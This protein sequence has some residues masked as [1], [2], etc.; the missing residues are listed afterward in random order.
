MRRISQILWP[1]LRLLLL[2]VSW[3]AW[4]VGAVFFLCMLGGILGIAC[5]VYVGEMGVRQALAGI[6]VIVLCAS[7]A[8]LCFAFRHFIRSSAV[9]V[10][11]GACLAVPGTARAQLGVIDLA[12]IAQLKT[13]LTQAR[14][15]VAEAMQIFSAL[16]HPQNVLGLAPELSAP[17]LQNLLPN[18]GQLNG[19]LSG[20][21]ASNPL[22]ALIA[23]IRQ[24]NQF[25]K[26]Q[27][28]DF[29]ANWINQSA[30][31]NAGV[32]AL[33]QNMVAALQQRMAGL[34]DLEQSCLG[35]ASDVTQLQACSARLQGE[36]NYAQT[37]LGEAQLLKTLADEQDR[38]QQQQ[39]MQKARQD[40][41][42]LYQNTQPLAEVPPCAICG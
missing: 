24:Q 38:A 30:A 27:G 34:N 28:S 22:S 25:Y 1:P 37:Q 14:A 31:G 4:A 41:D 18:T 9:L 3:L 26:P 6:L 7:A 42:E 35:G 17:S 13:I 12:S 20:S 2:P 32:Q 15:Q 33:A 21:G 19:I 39:I 10:L 8:A 36:Q 16:S 29:A 11:V 5:G 23:Q 40:A